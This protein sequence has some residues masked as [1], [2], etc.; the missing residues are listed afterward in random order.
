M[1][2][3]AP[4]LGEG[5]PDSVPGVRIWSPLGPYPGRW[6]TLSPGFGE[7]SSRFGPEITLGS[8]LRE[9]MPQ[10]TFHLIKVSRSGSSL[11]SCWS[12]DTSI[13][14]GKCH[15]GMDSAIDSARARLPESARSIEAFF[16]LQGESDAQNPADAEA[17]HANFGAFV[18]HIRHSWGDSTF[19]IISGLIDIQSYWPHAALVRDALVRVSEENTGMSYFETAGLATDGVHFKADGLKE[20]GRRMAARW[21]FH[22][23]GG[24]SA[25]TFPAAHRW[26]ILPRGN[27]QLWISGVDEAMDYRVVDI[28]GHAG[29]WS[30]CMKPLLLPR[31][32]A[33]NRRSRYL[34]LRDSDGRVQTLR[35]PAIWR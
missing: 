29:T 13:W 8:V 7:D 25:S 11:A 14:V 17:Y 35:I 6:S 32:R 1:S 33:G 30:R 28:D 22:G 2:G 12:R 3:Q 23:R 19:P 20:I 16:W 18:D 15:R 26:S 24:E 34:Q 9:W 4:W 27:L 21:L 31:G 5:L 10:D